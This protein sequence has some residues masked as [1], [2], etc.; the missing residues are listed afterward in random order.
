VK[1]FW[2]VCYLG[3]ILADFFISFAGDPIFDLIPIYLDVFRGDS[4]L[5]KQFLESYKLPF[6]CNISKYES[7][8]GGQKF[9]RLSYVAM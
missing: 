5:L 7:A 3:I 6:S 9:A 4:Y 8:E 2:Y 1:E